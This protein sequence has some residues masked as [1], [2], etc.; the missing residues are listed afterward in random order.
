MRECQADASHAS[1]WERV[2]SGKTIVARGGHVRRD[3]PPP[4][5]TFR[6]QTRMSI[7]ASGSGHEASDQ[8]GIRK[9][10]GKECTRQS[11]LEIE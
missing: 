10:K 7:R 1:H 5:D 3:Q 4:R 2:I 8:I 9:Q 11:N 6:V